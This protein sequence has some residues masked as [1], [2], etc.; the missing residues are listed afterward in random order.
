LSILKQNTI[1]SLIE[2]IR[3]VLKIVRTVSGINLPV[4]CYK[5]E[6]VDVG[7]CDYKDLCLVLKAMLPKFQP[8]T[9]PLPMLQYGIDCNCP[10]NIPA[11]QL[12]IIRERLE[13]PDASSSIANFMASGDFSIQLDTY[14]SDGAYAAIIIKFTVKPAKPSG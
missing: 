8:E 13:L 6:G 14:D 1:I 5:V 3:T 10:F 4:R 12:N 9:C 7:S 11:G 2:T